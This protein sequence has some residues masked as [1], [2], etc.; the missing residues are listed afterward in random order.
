MRKRTVAKFD[1]P[2]YRC[3]NPK[4]VSPR[5]INVLTNI[6]ATPGSHRDPCASAG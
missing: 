4:Q 6:F 3:V 5:E 1:M 2:H